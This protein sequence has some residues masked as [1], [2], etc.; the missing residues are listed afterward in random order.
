MII[1]EVNTHVFKNFR[2]YM[3]GYLDLWWKIE[4]RMWE[5]K[6]ECNIRKVGD[7]SKRRKVLTEYYH[8]SLPN[9][10][11]VCFHKYSMGNTILQYIGG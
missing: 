2:S 4:S 5:Y 11:T 10:C 3:H 7:F 6:R 1:T 8:T 9:V